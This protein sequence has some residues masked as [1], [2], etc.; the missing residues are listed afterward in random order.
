[1]ASELNQLQLLKTIK[2][3]LEKCAIE[4]M[5]GELV[6]SL[7]YNQGGIRD[8]Q[9]RRIEKINKKVLNSS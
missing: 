2:K 3:F 1:M 5:N 7:I 8:I 6:F 9:V 4:K